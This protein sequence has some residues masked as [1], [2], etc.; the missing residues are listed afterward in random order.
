MAAAGELATEY[1]FTGWE[2]GEASQA[3]QTCFKSWLENF[4]TGG[5]REER[6]MLSQVRAFFESH[7]TSRF[8]N[9]NAP[10][11]ERIQNRA[12]FYRTD[13]QGFRLY[14]VLAEVFKN[15]V[16]QG[17]DLKTVARVLLN[18]GWIVPANDGSPSQKPRIKGVGTPRVYVFTDKIW[19]GE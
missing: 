13:D 16:C 2:K 15:E 7:G 19:G 4:G 14:M 8:D 5:N 6:S 18:E 11:S 10:N 3:V 12:G 1:G 17:F 9:I